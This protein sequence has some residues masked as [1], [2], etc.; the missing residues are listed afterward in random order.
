MDEN[1]EQSAKNTSDEKA[2]A[3]SDAL[4]DELTRLGRKLVEVVDTAWN[5]EQRRQIQEEIRKGLNRMADSLESGFQEVSEKE[6]T[7]EVIGKASDVADDVVDKVRKSESANEI[8]AGLAAGFHALGDQLDKISREIHANQSSSSSSNAG[9]SS[10]E[11]KSD[12]QDIP[13]SEEQPHNK[14]DAS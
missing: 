8:A 12:A 6:K 14:H 9:K 10:A 13:I 1:Q 3:A 2:A 5:S 11:E 7:K 4:L